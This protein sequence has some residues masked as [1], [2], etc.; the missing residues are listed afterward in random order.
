MDSVRQLRV[1]IVDDHAV[2]RAGL[3][4]LIAAQ[5]DMTVVGEA[6]SG[7]EAFRLARDLR[8]E[9]VLMD[10]T[11][12]GMGGLEATTIIKREVPDTRV[13]MLTMHEDEGYLRAALASGAAGYLPK[14]AAD[15]EVILALR[16]VARGGVYI[17]PNQAKLLVEGMLAE[18]EPANTTRVDSYQNLSDREREVLRLVALGLTNSQV[19]QKLFISTKTVESYRSMVMDKLGLDNRAALVRYALHKD[20]L[21]QD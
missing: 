5:P 20:L 7:E 2:L 14:S 11:M 4:L 19:A 1:L 9:V 3:K 17:H 16:A 6:A 18:S 15:V 21:K 13:L 12:Q 8:P 10:I